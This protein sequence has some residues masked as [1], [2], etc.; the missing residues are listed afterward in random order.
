MQLSLYEKL[1]LELIDSW[2]RRKAGGLGIRILDLGTVAVERIVKNIGP[3]RT[4]AVEDAVRAAVVQMLHA[5]KFTVNTEELIRRGQAHGLKIANISDIQRCD[6][7]ELDRCNREHITFHET[8]A[9]LQ[10]AVLGLGGGWAALAD[11]TTVA[12]EIFHMAQEVAFCYGY[13]PNA[14]IEKEIIL[15][16]IL[17][18]IGG[19]ETRARCLNEIERLKNMASYA[20]E[21]KSG[22]DNVSVL[23][24]KALKEYMER[25]VTALLVR[26]V[27]QALPVVSVVTS[28]HNN[29]EMFERSGKTAF[30]VYRKRFIERKREL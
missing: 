19:S 26:L 3:D 13:D 17:A 29:Q 15:R 28:V 5:S 1:S 10:G 20:D 9:A 4:A 16:V 2:E 24:S 21:K 14:P 23:G 8:A 18:G 27:P 12:L 6:L 11:L 7:W 30:M 25:M 22:T